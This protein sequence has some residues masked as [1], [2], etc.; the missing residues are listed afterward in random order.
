MGL[1]TTPFN[2]GRTVIRGA[3]WFQVNAKP[4]GTRSS[5]STAYLHPIM[6]SRPNLEVWTGYRAERLTFDTSGQR[7]RATGVVL[8]TPDQRR[9]IEV[10]ATRETILSAGAI[11]GPSCSCSRAS[12]RPTHLREVGIEV[13]VDSP[14]VGE[15]L[16]DHPEGLVQWE[17]RQEMPTVS[18][19]WWQ[20]GIFAGSEGR[21][22]PDLM[23][24][25]GSVPFDMNIVRYGY[26]TA[27][28][29][30]C[31]TP[32]VTGAQSKGTVRLSSRDFH[33]KPKVDPRYF[34]HTHDREVMIRGIRVAREIAAPRRSRSGWAASSPPARTRRA[35]RSS[36]TTSE[37]THNTVYHP[38]CTVKM[39]A[40]GRR[41]G[42]GR[43]AA[44]PAGRRRPARGRR[45]DHARPHH[46]R[47]RASPR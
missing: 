20:I 27:D 35:T 26:P 47:T 5:A 37:T 42:A 32:N 22:T 45:L 29:T 10:T 9:S 7:P 30:F 16:Q 19:Q 3:N 17:A 12:G 18:T 6:E 34:S 23:Y 15:N 11:D 39:G 33:D 13:L 25:Y 21:E 28:N 44:A 8:R 2:T 41:A 38:A 40:G 24:H 36:S 4:D 46:R 43:R 14:G 31:L 1:P